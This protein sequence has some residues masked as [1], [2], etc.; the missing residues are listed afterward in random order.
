MVGA[1]SRVGAAKSIPDGDDET[2]FETAGLDQDTFSDEYADTNDVRL[3]YVI[4]GDGPPVVLLHGFAQTWYEWH[5]IMPNLAQ[6]YTVIAP[7][8]RGMGDSEK[9]ED[10][11]DKKTVA[12][13][14]RGLV[15]TLDYDRIRLIGHDMGGIVSYSYAA[16]YG[17][18][19]D[20]LV[21]LETGVPGVQIEG[22]TGNL[23]TSQFF[24]APEIPELLI[25]EREREFLAWFYDYYAE[26]PDAI[27]EEDID[28]YAQA[29][30]A[31]G[32]L[33]AA[34]S[35]YRALPQ[36]AKDN[37]QFTQ[38]P[39]QMPIL[40]LGGSLFGQA[41]LRIMRAIA[42]D[43]RGGVLE[44]SGHWIAEERPQVLTQRLFDFFGQDGRGTQ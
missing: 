19:L 17:D 2:G 10:G 11:Y 13:D 16:Q 23:W 29:Y 24:A 41:V 3:H 27:R 44:G 7:D 36:D 14:I 28:V 35:Y 34:L 30:A 40:A 25:N 42:T 6:Q 9:P 12:T 33:E 22:F 20:Q 32:A 26:D 37:Q 1:I 39:L 5:K 43:V 38:T 18:S 31:P 8:M 15:R 21:M 4:G